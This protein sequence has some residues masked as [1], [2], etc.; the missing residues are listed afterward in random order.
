MAGPFTQSQPQNYSTWPGPDHSALTQVAE[1]FGQITGYTEN[2]W[3]IAESALTSISGAMT[4]TIPDAGSNLDF[5]GINGP[6]VGTKPGHTDA[7][8]L[9]VNF[10]KGEMDSVAELAASLG[11]EDFIPVLID[12][13]VFDIP[14]PVY[15][16]PPVPTDPMPVI[17]DDGPAID[18]PS[19]PPP[20]EYTL[21]PL[22]VLADIVIP[23]PPEY[24]LPDFSAR[25]PDAHL[26]VP[27][28]Q[29]V[30][31]EIPYDSDL[32]NELKTWMSYKVLRGG[33]GLGAA[34]EAAIWNRAR[35][36]QYDEEFQ[37]QVEAEK[38]WSAR[39]HEEPPGALRGRILELHNSILRG[40]EN[41][42][43]DIM[44]EMARLAQANTQFAV[45]QAVA[46]ETVLMDYANKVN[47]R[48]FEAAKVGVEMSIAIYNAQVAFY[49]AQL[50]TYQA[51]AAVFES[52]VR[53]EIAKMEI[54]KAQI[55]GVKAI[56]DVQDGQVRLYTA[57]VGALE[58]LM[59]MYATEMESVK[60]K[61]DINR[62]RIEKYRATIEAKLAQINAI[63][64]KYNLWQAQV[65]GEE[66]R[67]KIYETEVRAYGE[68]MDAVKAVAELDSERAKVVLGKNQNKVEVLKAAVQKYLGEIEG[69]SSRVE[70]EAKGA[71]A[72]TQRYAAEISAENAWL[73][74]DVQRYAA[75]VSKVVEQ[76]RVAMQD[77]AN[78]LQAAIAEKE[79]AVE[80]AKAMGQIGGQLAAAS[81]TAVS[82][83]A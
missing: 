3:A 48:A 12:V 44:V 54:F 4:V 16:I 15:T 20:P 41:L 36:R 31:H 29:F 37:K 80:G 14:P 76:G 56:V 66:T 46:F 47:Q 2:A 35:D 27:E 78:A 83:S 30:F 17:D 5:T 72:D 33:T 21:P 74:A 70:A 60:I 62:I 59:K 43:N 49:N 32:A 8:K 1:R 24:S 81:M 28:M 40:R 51:E 64:S 6:N 22:P 71:V 52:R 10:D 50:A 69:E 53:A 18:D 79:I 65:A 42:S 63:T 75:E 38:Y 23:D 67:A 19:F 26:V 13:P 25:L 61:A 9:T 39:G 11:L 7:D 77:A 68:Q 45:S 34:V 55:E 73:I 82:A 57:Q 58:T